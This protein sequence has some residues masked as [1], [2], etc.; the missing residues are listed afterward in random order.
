MGK[1]FIN[2][3]IF[4]FL[5]YVLISFILFHNLE[6]KKK[7]YPD[8]FQGIVDNYPSQGLSTPIYSA[9]ND[10]NWIEKYFIPTIQQR[11]G[12]VINARGSSGVSAAKAISDHAHDWILGSNGKTVSM[13]VSS[14]G[15]YGIEKGLI[16][17]FPVI[18][19]QG[20]Y[21]IIQG[22]KLNDFSRQRIDISAKELREEKIAA[23]L[24]N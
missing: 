12:A 24:K 17:S 21:R 13:G 23:G 4:F 11:G 14:D 2:S 7:R 20:S 19:H 1:S 5:S 6:K 9:I 8:I 16:Y 15:S 18:C 10:M 22:L 3:V